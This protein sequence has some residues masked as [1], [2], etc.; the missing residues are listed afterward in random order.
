MK[1]HVIIIYNLPEEHQDEGLNAE[2]N[3]I[4]KFNIKIVLIDDVTLG[5]YLIKI[6]ILEQA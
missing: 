6:W 2:K 5:F 4:R 1:G 3:V